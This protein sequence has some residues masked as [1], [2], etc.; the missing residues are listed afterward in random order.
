MRIAEEKLILQGGVSAGNM[1]QARMESGGHQV[2]EQQ[3]GEFYLQN[4]E[5]LK[6]ALE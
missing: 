6:E 1:E 4:Q 2:E 3:A 5:K